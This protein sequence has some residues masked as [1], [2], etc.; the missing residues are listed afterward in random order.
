MENRPFGYL[1]PVDPATVWASEPGD[2]VPWLEASENLRCLGDAL[3]LDLEPV[4]REVPVGRFRADFVCRD[5]R[6]DS[7]V[8]IEA[9]LGPSDHSHL[10]QLLTYSEGLQAEVVVWLGTRFHDEHRVVLGRFNRSSDLDLRCFAV[11]IDLWT[12]A[13]SPTAPQF[14]VLAAPGDWSGPAAGTPGH[15]PAPAG[16]DAVPAGAADGAPLGDNPIRIRRL[17]RGLTLKQVASAAGISRAC[18]AHIETGRNRGTPKTLAAIEKVL[19][20]PP[21][22]LGRSGEHSSAEPETGEREGK[23]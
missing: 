2:F 19:N 12:I 6:T 5:R 8:V 18:L 15:R 9:Q 22:A 4:G 20:M 21:G 13:G 17:S 10:G 7:T 3:G 1:D 11:A 14:T 16:A 23:R